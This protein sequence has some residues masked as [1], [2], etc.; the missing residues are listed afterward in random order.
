MC[1]CVCVCVFMRVGYVLCICC[2]WVD[3]VQCHATP[4]ESKAI[5]CSL[6]WDAATYMAEARMFEHYTM[7]YE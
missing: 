7:R 5:L 6:E 3:C 2:V 1:V 4:S